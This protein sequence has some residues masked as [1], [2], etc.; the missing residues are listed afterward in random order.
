MFLVFVFRGGITTTRRSPSRNV[1]GNFTALKWATGFQST[2]PERSGAEVGR[3]C[4]WWYPV[5]F[6]ART[7]DVYA[8]SPSG[9]EGWR[10][11]PRHASS[12]EARDAGFQ[13]DLLSVSRLA[14]LISQVGPGT[15]HRISLVDC[16]TPNRHNSDVLGHR[17]FRTAIHARRS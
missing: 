14:T 16:K 4:V 9:I 11:H 1:D 10:W 8:S 15:Y 13:L 3:Q 2:P 7:A 6:K 5:I 17:H 12:R